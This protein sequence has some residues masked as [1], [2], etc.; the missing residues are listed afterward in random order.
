MK[1]KALLK[2]LWTSQP[3]GNYSWDHFTTESPPIKVEVKSGIALPLAA[4]GAPVV[5]AMKCRNNDRNL[6]IPIDDLAKGFDLQL[7]FTKGT[8]E[9]SDIIVPSQNGFV[10]IYPFD[11]SVPFGS[12]QVWYVGA[13]VEIDCLLV[14]SNLRTWVL[15]AC[16]SPPTVFP[17]SWPLLTLSLSLSHSPPPS[18]SV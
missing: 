3:L 1:T 12:A 11:G 5:I 14:V 2:T 10:G 4:S 17:L 18:H 6:Q 7:G 13:Y 16:C 9:R 15:G 8:N